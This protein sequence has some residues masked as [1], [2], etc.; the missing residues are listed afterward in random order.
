MAAATRTAG[1]GRVGQS[2]GASVCRT[3]LGTSNAAGRLRSKGNAP[4]TIGALALRSAACA[5]RTSL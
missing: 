4:N 2:G 5:A 3:A 1:S